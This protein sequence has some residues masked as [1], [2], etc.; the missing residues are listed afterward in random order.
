MDKYNLVLIEDAAHSFGCK[1][2]SYPNKPYV[3]SFANL[4]TFSFHPVKNITTCEGGMVVTNN[5]EYY[6]I[7]YQFPLRSLALPE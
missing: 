7:L 5:K 3:G 6:D 1:I 4:T 2:N